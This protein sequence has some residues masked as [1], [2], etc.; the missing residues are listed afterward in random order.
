MRHEA[1]AGHYDRQPFWL[2][3][4]QA[5]PNARKASEMVYQFAGA[6]RWADAERALVDYS[7]LQAKCAAG[8]V[9]DLDANYNSVLRQAPK[10]GL[11]QRDGLQLLTMSA[12]R[13]SLNAVSRFSPTTFSTNGQAVGIRQPHSGGAIET[14]GP[15]IP[16]S[17]AAPSAHFNRPAGFGLIRTMIGHTKRVSDIALSADGRRAISAS[18]DET[19]KVWDLEAGVELRTIRHVPDCS[20]R[21]AMTPDG[22]LAVS[23]SGGNTAIVWDL[24][25][26]HQVRTLAGHEG[27]VNAVK[28]CCEGRRAVSTAGERTLKVWDLEPGVELR[29]IRHSRSFGS[30]AVTPDGRLAVSISGD[31]ASVWDLVSGSELLSREGS[32]HEVALTPDGRRVVSA[33]SNG[34]LVVWD[35]D[36]GRDLFTVSCINSLYG[37]VSCVAVSADGRRA[38]SLSSDESLDVWDLETDRQI[39]LCTLGGAGFGRAV[40]VSADGRRAVSA[41]EDGTVKVWDLDVGGEHRR[42]ATH[43]RSVLGVAASADGRRGVSV[44]EDSTIIAW[45]LETR[46]VLVRELYSEFAFYHVAMFADGQGAVSASA[47]GSLDVWNLDPNWVPA[48][49]YQTRIGGHCQPNYMENVYGVALTADGQRVLSA[50]ADKTLKVCELKTGRVLQNLT[51]HSEC[52]RSVAVVASGEWAI[53]AS[54]DKTLKIW[55]LENGSELVTLKGHTYSVKGV[56]LSPDGRRAVSASA[57]QTLKIWDLES[58]RE[59]LTLTGHLGSVNAVAISPDGRRVVSASADKTIKVWDLTTGKEMATFNCDTEALCCA[60]YGEGDVIAGDEMRTFSPFGVLISS[61]GRCRSCLK[62]P[63]KSSC[64]FV[65]LLLHTAKADTLQA[66]G[67]EDKPLLGSKLSADS[68]AKTRLGFGEP[69]SPSGET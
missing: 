34:K 41:C 22:R 60:F 28:I 10:A 17:L 58:A 5:L 68:G 64:F 7:F 23:T 25:S 44:A 21:V 56:A 12:L 62:A 47:D 69:L 16:R 49:K 38:V 36:T 63:R 61:P 32:F 14:D 31:T 67:A 46:Q 55:D 51:G 29:T 66:T 52:V 50:H 37:T 39:P 27:L 15:G 8:M 24:E 42:H 30:V 4:D 53:S 26:G 65:P 18:A 33:E 54:D 35:S 3:D 20:G 6:N 11:L 48:N 43:S 40:A 1:S 2:N 45:D 59:L 57:D 13:L 9:M 19:F